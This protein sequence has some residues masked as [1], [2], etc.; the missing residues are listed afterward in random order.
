MSD[1]CDPMDYSQPG[2]SVHGILQARIL[3]WIA[4]SLCRESSQPRNWTWV[5]CTAGRFFS[6]WATR[7]AQYIAMRES[8]HRGSLF[9]SF[10]FMFGNFQNKKFKK[11]VQYLCN[12]WRMLLFKKKDTGYQTVNY[13]LY[14]TCFRFS[15][16]FFFLERVLW[17]CTFQDE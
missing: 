7:E 6:N 15:F 12:L 4:I 17:N 8:V 5:S 10:Y 1:T 13:F 16:F 3:E 2:S 9:H 14:F 11:K